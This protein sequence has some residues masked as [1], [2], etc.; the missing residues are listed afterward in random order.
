MFLFNF[1]IIFSCT[2]VTFKNGW[3]QTGIPRGTTS[4]LQQENRLA[5]CDNK[6]HRKSITRGCC[7]LNRSDEVLFSF[8]LRRKEKKKLRKKKE[9]WNHSS[10]LLLCTKTNSNG[11]LRFLLAIM[12]YGGGGINVQNKCNIWSIFVSVQQLSR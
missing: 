7:L 4:L 12:Y 6:N 11:S 10:I 2:S 3:L 8:L 1:L 5:N 9:K